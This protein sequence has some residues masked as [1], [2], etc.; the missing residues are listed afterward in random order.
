MNL[1]SLVSKIDIVSPG[2]SSQNEGGGDDDEDTLLCLQSHHHVTPPTFPALMKVFANLKF[3]E[4]KLCSFP[5]SS[6]LHVSRLNC[7]ICD[8][9]SIQC[10]LI[11]AVK[12][13]V[14]LS[15]RRSRDIPLKSDMKFDL[16][17]VETTMFLLR[18]MMPHW[19]KT[20]KKVVFSSANMQ[21]SG[22]RGSVFTGNQELGNFIDLI[23]TSMVY[24]SWLNWLNNPR[25]VTYWIKGLRNDEHSMLRENVWILYGLAFPWEK[26]R[27]TTTDIV[28]RESIVKELLGAF[29]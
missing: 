29:E 15:T 23:S 13:A 22:L 4:I 26:G 9:D 19:P 2:S 3:L 27:L 21:G 20:L 1:H 5:S 14:L 12:T 7:M 25:N 17:F 16:S 24:E 28:V 8:G 10:E 18:K 6:S 11:F